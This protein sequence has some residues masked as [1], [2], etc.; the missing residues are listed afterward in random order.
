MDDRLS[1]G[2]GSHES[3]KKDKWK[4][5]GKITIN[6]RRQIKWITIHLNR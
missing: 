3:R 6:E 4:C 5:L 1:S 2:F